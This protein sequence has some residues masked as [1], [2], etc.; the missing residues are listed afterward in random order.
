MVRSG[1]GR[2]AR[3]GVRD[4]GRTHRRRLG[5]AVAPL[6]RSE[7]TKTRLCRHRVA[8]LGPDGVARSEEL[9]ELERVV[10]QRDLSNA[11]RPGSPCGCLQLNWRRPGS[12]VLVSTLETVGAA[13]AALGPQ[14]WE[15]VRSDRARPRDWS[16]TRYWPRDD[17]G[18]RRGIGATVNEPLLPADVRSFGD[19][20]ISEVDRAVVGKRD[21]VE[22]VLIGMLAK[23]HVLAGGSSWARENAHRPF[24]RPGDRPQLR[25][26]PVHARSRALRRHRSVDL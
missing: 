15:F 13:A 5:Q 12:S 18:H 9:V 6:F 21:V 19:L 3:D 11:Q 26:D 10:L 20:V 8:C 23:G 17:R 7:P 16:R 14:L 4:S 24:L 25:E 1:E 2:R 22:L